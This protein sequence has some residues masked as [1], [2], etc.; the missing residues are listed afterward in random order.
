[1]HQSNSQADSD[2]GGNGKPNGAKKIRGTAA[3]NHKEKE[4]RE[5]R[6][7]SRQEAATKRKGR[8]E[9]RRVEGQSCDKC[10]A[11]IMLTPRIADAETSEETPLAQSD[12]VA[13]SAEPTAPPV[14]PPP[15]PEPLAPETP[16]VVPAPVPQ[17]KGGRPPNARKGKLGK[18]QYT[19]DRDVSEAQDPPANR[20]QS[21][22]VAK[23]EENG[24]IAQTKV[25][26]HD[27]KVAKSK[28]INSKITMTDMKKRV[29]AILQFI[30]QTEYE[31]GESMLPTAENTTG[32]MLRGLAD[33]LPMI[34]VNGE[35]GTSSKAG[36]TGQA[37]R[38]FKDL[39]CKEMI[40][41]LTKQL[42]KWQD[43]FT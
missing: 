7:K 4:L 23:G 31:L 33:S 22:D 11:S 21:R 34:K 25:S 17:K 26:N 27:V 28:A 5:E 36:E 19:K 30:S 1:M 14:E 16:P 24:P 6:E 20:S 42:L 29:A 2:D 3:R 43:E 35:N 18:N 32:K 37:A 41:E 8:A 39:S 40:I 15:L 9:R 13:K 10:V 12:S 38:E